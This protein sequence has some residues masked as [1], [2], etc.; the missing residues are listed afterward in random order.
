MLIDADLRAP[1]VARVLRPEE[2]TEGLTGI[3]EG[4]VEMREAIQPLEIDCLYLISGGQ[5]ATNPAELLARPEF[6]ILIAELEE[7]FDCIIIDSAPVLPVC[8]TLLL[9]PHA[10]S[11]CVVIQAGKTPRKAILRAKKLLVEAGASI[12]GLVMNM[13]SPKSDPDHYVYRQKYGAPENYGGPVY[14][15]RLQLPAPG[16]EAAAQAGNGANGNKHA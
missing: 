9:V 4:R 6:G 14:S 5:I 8:D 12:G 15:A 2:K 16:N 1:A 13:L 11:V 7:Q 10:E 3:L